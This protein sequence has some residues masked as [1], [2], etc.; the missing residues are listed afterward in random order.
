M[1]LHAI[2]CA[3]RGLLLLVRRDDLRGALLRWCGPGPGMEPVGRSVRVRVVVSGPVVVSGGIGVEIIAREMLLM[4]LMLMLGSLRLL[5]LLMM[6]IVMVRGSGLRSW[7]HVR[8]VIVHRVDA[9]R[10]ML[11]A[12]V[13]LGRSLTGKVAMVG[14]LVTS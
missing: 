3:E 12:R 6:L 10:G 8:R 1:E 14:L 9:H 7:A 11:L 2:D 4:L 5:V 13:R